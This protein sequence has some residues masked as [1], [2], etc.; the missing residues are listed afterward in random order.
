MAL[1][2]LAPV[3]DYQSMLNR[4]FWFTTAAA[5]GAVW[6]LRR[7][8]PAIDAAL[9]PLDQAIAWGASNGLP[10]RA[11]DLLPALG[12]G[13]IT[14]VFHV[15]ARL[16]DWLLIRETFDVDVIISE[17]ARQL[18]IDLS[19][20]GDEELRRAR[21]GLMRA[22]FYP[23][24]SGPQPAI[25]RQLVEQA[26][27]A[28]SWFWVGLE[29]AFLFVVASF[30]LIAAG[31]NPI[32]LQTLVGSLLIAT[33]ALPAIRRQCRRYAIAQVRAILADAARTAAARSAFTHLTGERTHVRL[34]A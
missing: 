22:A 7:N 4:I 26:L 25:D 28:W 33:V 12:I 15:H 17:F 1:N 20:F 9:S 14:R 8:V 19:P 5:L 30:V 31:V 24:V 3:T 32:G 21:H 29:A 27:D 11:G 2:P 10:T 23:F 6:L 18:S 34:A 13:V 16:S